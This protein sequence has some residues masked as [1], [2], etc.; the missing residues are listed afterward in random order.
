MKSSFSIK[1]VFIAV[2]AV[3]GSLLLLLGWLCF[4]ALDWSSFQQIRT[5]TAVKRDLDARWANLGGLDLRNQASLIAT[6]QFNHR[7]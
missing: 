4:H 1:R 7:Y 2:T 3:L 6:W 5:V